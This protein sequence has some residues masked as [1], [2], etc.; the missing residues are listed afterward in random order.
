MLVGTVTA[1]LV[2]GAGVGWVLRDRPPPP[3]EQVARTVVVTPSAT[4][5][6]TQAQWAALREA[7]LAAANE[8]TLADALTQAQAATLAAQSTLT[9]SADEVA[10]DAVRAALAA[11]VAEL[12]TALAADDP[13]ADAIR[14]LVV[15]VQTAQGTVVAAHEAWLAAAASPTPRADDDDECRTTYDGPAFYTSAPTEGGDG[16]NGN[17]PASMLAATSWGV[18]SQGTRYWLRTDA[19]A[20]L[21]RLNKDFRAEFG[22]DLDL[23]LTYRDYATQV[24]MRK[25]L[26]SIAA[27]PGTSR[28][29]TGL[30]LD[31]PEWPCEYGY[32]TPERDWLVNN[33]PDYGWVSPSWA[34]SNGSNPEYWHYEFTG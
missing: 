22:H 9:E 3:A 32:D 16:S 25:A 5:G 31:V 30:A 2:V 21:E 12:Q 23:D 4:P 24:A 8:A 27:E 1:A 34:R 28:H 15:E 26:G 6:M 10:D 33:G 14:A 17:V 13:D 19:T 18:D 7:E 20:A 29:G 11:L